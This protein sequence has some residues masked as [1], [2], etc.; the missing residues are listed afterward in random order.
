MK[1]RSGY[2]VLSIILATVMLFS[3]IPMQT[4]FAETLEIETVGSYTAERADSYLI[5]NTEQVE[6]DIEEH[7]VSYDEKVPY[8]E[9]RRFI[10]SLA[11]GDDA[12]ANKLK[13]YYDEHAED[14][15]DINDK[16]TDYIDVGLIDVIT[17]EKS[18]ADIANMFRLFLVCMEDEK[19]SDEN[20]Q[21]ILE[22]IENGNN[23]YNS[24][25]AYVRY[26]ELHN[27]DNDNLSE[28]QEGYAENN[29]AVVTDENSDVQETDSNTYIR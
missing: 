22:L 14:K 2:R 3:A 5:N 1:K 13:D 27:A 6:F 9:K 29:I 23:I 4:L 21:K 19:I 20:K 18:N 16:I 26:S 10:S 25:T 8:M 28:Q 17:S 7:S 11:E 15:R 12:A 24:I